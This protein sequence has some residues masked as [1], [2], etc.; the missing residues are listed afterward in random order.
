L[1][2]F[3][4]SVRK[5]REVREA[6]SIHKNWGCRLPSRS[7]FIDMHFSEETRVMANAQTVMMLLMALLLRDLAVCPVVACKL[8][9]AQRYKFQKTLMIASMRPRR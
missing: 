5:S 6:Q 2:E 9:V 3:L 1:K 7:K 4:Q 8:H